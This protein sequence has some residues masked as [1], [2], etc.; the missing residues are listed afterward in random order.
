MSN[1]LA[2]VPSSTPALV[3]NDEQLAL[4]KRTIATGFSDD[5]LALFLNQCKRTG[6]DPFA[7]QIYGIKRGG[8]LTIQVSI[9]GFRLI[10]QRSEGYAGQDGPYWC[11]DDGQWR[12][13][14]LDAA[15][16]PSA[17]KVGVYRLGFT[18]PVYA[19][20]TW[21]EYA[22]QGGMWSKMPALMLAKCA[23]SLAL[24]KAFPQELS[25]LYTQ[26]EMAQ[27]E[28]R[29]APPAVIDTSTGEELPPLVGAP[30]GY[31]NWLLDLEAVAATGTAPLRDAWTKS[32]PEYRAHLTQT[33]AQHWATLKQRAE[34]VQA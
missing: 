7:R 13:V 25:G 19:V 3:F 1:H 11:A 31:D 21:K 4:I 32:K 9:D 23:E 17:A 29:H 15:K 2:L 20:A 33:N 30:E 16:H 10:A 24:R 34:Q 27:D 18:A 26:D 12:D 8:K 5:E 28:P 22:Q 6:L 14:W